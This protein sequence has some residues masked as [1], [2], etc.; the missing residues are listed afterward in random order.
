MSTGALGKGPVIVTAFGNSFH[1]SG[2][3]ARG[4]AGLFEVKDEPHAG[5]V[6]NFFEERCLDRQCRMHIPGDFGGITF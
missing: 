3:V 2:P 6:Y 5:L 1:R 4:N